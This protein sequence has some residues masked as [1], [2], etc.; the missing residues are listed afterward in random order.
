MGGGQP[1]KEGVRGGRTADPKAHAF[2]LEQAKV[3]LKRLRAHD[4]N[5]SKVEV[6]RIQKIVRLRLDDGARDFQRR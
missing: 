5:G 6:V 4:A 1:T 2:R 3:K